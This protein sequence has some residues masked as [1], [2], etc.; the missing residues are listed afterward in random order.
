[1]YYTTKQ[2]ATQWGLISTNNLDQVY[3]GCD[4]T[5]ISSGS[6]RAS[7]RIQT[8]A[9]WNSGL[10]ILDLEHMPQ[11]IIDI[12]MSRSFFSLLVSSLLVSPPVPPSSP[13]LPHF[14]PLP[15][16]KE[17]GLEAGDTEEG[18][19]ER[20]GGGLLLSHSLPCLLLQHLTTLDI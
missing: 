11:G 17:R 13:L 18:E 14:S 2:Q 4:S 20:K 5:T 1:M 16:S 19:G 3:I 10:F 15:P 6:G 8:Q 7:V 9:S 12:S